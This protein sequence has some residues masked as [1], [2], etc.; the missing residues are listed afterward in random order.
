MFSWRSLWKPLS[1]GDAQ[2]PP[3][4]DEQVMIADSLMLELEFHIREIERMNRDHEQE[5]R[6]QL[7]GVDYSWL[8][9]VPVKSYDIPQLVRLDLDEL[10]C[11]VKPRECGKVISLFRDSLLNKPRVSDL[12][13]IMRACI[14]QVLNERPREET[15]TE[16][17]TKRTVSLTN[18]KLR[19]HTKITPCDSDNDVESQSTIDTVCSR[20]ENVSPTFLTNKSHTLPLQ[21]QGSFDHLPV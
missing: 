15:L 17:V 5:E 6:R 8:V 16:W 3:E 1:G 13:L 9:T 19:P 18:I 2:R 4:R 20:V 10:C 21:S 11:R 14:Q 7:T 12:P